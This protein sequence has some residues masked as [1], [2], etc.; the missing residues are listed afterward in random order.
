MPRTAVKKSR[1]RSVSPDE[2]SAAGTAELR[3]CVNLDE[4][5][6]SAVKLACDILKSDNASIV[7]ADEKGILTFRAQHGVPPRFASRWRKRSS[8]GLSGVVF[9]T[10]QPYVSP[11]LQADTEYK[12]K[13]LAQGWLR[14][15]LV[16]PLKIGDGVRGCLYV[17]QKSVRAFTPE[18]VRLASLFADHVSMFIESTTLLEQERQQRQ[19]SEALLDVVG[20]PSLSLSLKQILVR[21]CQSVVK[22]T[23]GERCSIFLF[24]EET[25]TLE[26]IMSV[27][28]Q[29]A[30]DPVLWDEFRA[31]AGLKIPEI[32]GIGEAIKAQEPIVQENALKS[33]VIPSFWIETFGLK[34]LALYP[35]VHREKTIGIM[36]V[37]SFSKFVHFPADEVE[38]LAAIAKHAAIII[39]NSRLYEQEQRQHQ[40]A[41]A[42]VDVLTAAASTLSMKEVLIKLCQA[43][44]NIT[45]GDRCS[46]FMTN[47]EKRG[48]EPVMSLGIEDPGL[49]ERFRN[50][51]AGEDTSLLP[52]NRRLY[53][54][55]TRW[56]NP[57]VI[58]DAATTGLL[59]RWWIETF[60][61]KSLVHYPLRVKDRTIGMMTVDAFRNRVHFPQ[62]EIDTLAAIAKQAAVI[63]ENAHLYEQEQQQRRRAE[64][65]VNVLSAAASDLSF[66]KVL[67]TISQ[68]VLDFSVGERCSI[69]LFNE[70]TH[71][72]D[73]VMAVGPGDAAL[74]KKWR[75]SGGLPIPEFK[76]IGEAITAREPIV[77][78]NA[79]A[80]KVLPLAWVKEFEVK[81]AVVCPL[82]H[83]EKTVGLLVVNTFSDFTHFPQEEVE[84]LAA[85]ARQAAIIIEN[86]RLHNRLK[87]QAITDPVTGL[88][89]HRHI[90]E[91]LDE[92][93]ARASRGSQPLA[94]LMMDM[95]NFKFFND[96]RGHL[97][98]DEALRHAAG[99]FRKALRVSDIIGRYGGDE[100]L[101][102]LPE[103]GREA[104][105]QVGQRIV[106]LLAEHPFHLTD[107]DQQESLEV[108]IGVACYPR[109]TTVSLELV[110]LADAALYNAKGMGGAQVIPVGADSTA[111][112][113]SGSLGF[114]FLHSLLNALAHKD[115]YTRRHCEDNVRYVDQLADQLNL[116]PEARESLRKAALLHD[117]GKIAIPDSTL[118]KPGPLDNGEWAVM[119]QHVQFGETIVRGISQLSDAIEPVATHHERYDG[120]GYPRGLKGEAIP[121]LGRILAVIDAYS[122]MTLDRPYRKALNHRQAVKE[123]RNGAGTQFDP[124]IVEAFLAVIATKE[125]AKRRAA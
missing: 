17:G 1:E 105:E 89:N 77:E 11:D 120:N 101:A 26:P 18:E 85:V 21:L 72:L 24:N 115:P 83:R 124:Q 111:P 53:E 60:N 99:V 97:V 46:I 108:S 90:H 69:F 44:V 9:R 119:R 15:L 34:S 6:S 84:T 40:R 68:S 116:P 93:F 62:E 114:G 49:W 73:P 110:A 36:E 112:V 98:G 71:T 3:H 51:A 67:A 38:T 7:L 113:S 59:S 13:G 117:V 16:V 8:E 103:T 30:E 80:S 63:I 55:V 86:A 61:L 121:V 41:E 25:H 91:R 125:Q 109:D 33:S 54:A 52:E 39:E 96:T 64:A 19:R 4:V 82:V 48:L 35:L 5:L 2:P 70:E 92:E 45:V 32:R 27:M 75:A 118:L 74:F 122:A 106:S 66:K 102:V 78:E 23:I 28:S 100:F 43:V 57:I 37:D 94:V 123:L 107:S 88:Y 87:E 56:E 50:P 20:A 42:L 104:A 31:S 22:L 29:K 79:P 95:D 81:S 65:L 76:G 10:G 12:G 14:A 47:E 58:E